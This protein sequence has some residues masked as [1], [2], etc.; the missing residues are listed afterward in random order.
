MAG[1]AITYLNFGVFK[2]RLSNR[3]SPQVR[4]GGVPTKV[5]SSV[6]DSSSA[7]K[8]SLRLLQSQDPSGIGISK[9]LAKVSQH[10]EMQPTSQL[11]LPL[12]RQVVLGTSHS[13]LSVAISDHLQISMSSQ[14]LEY[15][16]R[17][18]EEWLW[19]DGAITAYRQRE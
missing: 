12:L 19:P 10:S 18:C 3:V 7:Q 15:S 14:G 2:T 11:F 6:L 1:V 4:Y 5:V 8:P 17:R 9:M 16:R 13:A